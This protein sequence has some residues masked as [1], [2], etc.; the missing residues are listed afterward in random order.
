MTTPSVQIELYNNTHQQHH[1]K[2][3]PRQG[4]ERRREKCSSENGKEKRNKKKLNRQT[5][6]TEK[7]E[8]VVKED[9]KKKPRVYVGF[10]T[11]NR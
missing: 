8:K 5:N 9:A 1:P 7:D 4:E 11:S 2:T 6:Y 3:T 10:Q